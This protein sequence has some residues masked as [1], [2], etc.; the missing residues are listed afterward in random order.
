MDDLINKGDAA[1][2]PEEATKFYQQAEDQ[3]AKDLPYIPVYTYRDQAVWSEKMK[4][5]KI[6]IF[7]FIDYF[8]TQ[9]K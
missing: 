5:V 3:I 1:K 9:V 8:A 2:T 6:D 4:T 7:N